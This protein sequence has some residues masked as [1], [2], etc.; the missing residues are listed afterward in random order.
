MIRQNCD[1]RKPRTACAEVAKQDIH[2]VHRLDLPLIMLMY[3]V[4]HAQARPQRRYKFWQQMT[5]HNILT[6]LNI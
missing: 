3:Q 5:V 1:L 4:Y 2:A 6:L